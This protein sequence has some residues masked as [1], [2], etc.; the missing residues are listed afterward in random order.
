MGI[1]YVETEILNGLFMSAHG[2]SVLFFI[3]GLIGAV[4]WG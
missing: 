3:F 1:L 2:L 4:A